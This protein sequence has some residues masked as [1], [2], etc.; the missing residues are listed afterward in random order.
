MKLSLLIFNVDVDV[1]DNEKDSSAA[2]MV[3]QGTK[4]GVVRAT[5][6]KSK[7]KGKSGGSGGKG[8]KRKAPVPTRAPTRTPITTRETA[9]GCNVTCSST[10]TNKV[11]LQKA[12]IE[13]ATDPNILQQYGP[14]SDWCFPFLT[15]LDGLFLGPNKFNEDISCWD[16][17]HVTSMIAMFVKSPFNQD[18]GQWNVASVTNMDSMFEEAGAFN[19][20]IGKWNVSKVISLD[21]MFL[22]AAAFDQNIGQWDVSNV[23]GTGEM[24]EGALSFNQNLCPWGSKMKSNVQVQD[25]FAFSGCADDGDPVLSGTPVSPLCYVCP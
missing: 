4:M 9:P 10:F 8:P 12:A 5:A 22:K 6:G 25:M 21:A 11:I 19:Q 14:I 24:F 17:S 7:R 16:V 15:E 20:D 2:T 23:L 13:Y 1:D 18:I 3:R